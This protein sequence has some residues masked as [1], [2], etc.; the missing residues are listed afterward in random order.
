MVVLTTVAG[1]QGSLRDISG[2]MYVMGFALFHSNRGP[3][4]QTKPALGMAAN[5]ADES[6]LPAIF[7]G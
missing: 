3:P 1:L 2:I 6:L 7:Q 5:Q 4:P